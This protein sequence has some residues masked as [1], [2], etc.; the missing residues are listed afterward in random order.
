MA[1]NGVLAA[2]FQ[3]HGSG[4]QAVPC[5]LSND[6]NRQAMVRISAGVAVLYEDISALEVTLKASQQS[7]EA[8]PSE[9]AV[10]LSP[11]DFVLGRLLMHNKLVGCSPGG[12]LACVHD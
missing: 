2:N 7:A 5:F 11:P 1:P 9:G 12:V 4:E 3:K 10:V 6:A 8:L